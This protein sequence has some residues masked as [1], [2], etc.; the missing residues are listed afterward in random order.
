MESLESEKHARCQFRRRAPDPVPRG[1]ARKSQQPDLRIKLDEDILR[2][3]EE[4]SRDRVYRGRTKAI[5]RA[6]EADPEFKVK[7][8]QLFR[9]HLTLVPPARFIESMVLKLLKRY[10]DED[11]A[12]A[13]AARGREPAGQ[14]QDMAGSADAD[15]MQGSG[16]APLGQVEWESDEEDG[17]DEDAAEGGED[18]QEQDHAESALPSQSPDRGPSRRGGSRSQSSP[19]SAMASV[20]VGT[21]L[22]REFDGD[23]Y[24]G[25]VFAITRAN[26]GGHS[27]DHMDMERWAVVYDDADVEEL[28]VHDLRTARIEP[29]NHNLQQAGHTDFGLVSSMGFLDLKRKL[30]R[31]ASTVTFSDI[32]SCGI[33]LDLPSFEKDHASRLSLL[34]H[35]RRACVLRVLRLR[36]LERVLRRVHR[37]LGTD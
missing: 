11:K 30:G 32:S 19:T 31:Q 3:I 33:A 1:W 25:T 37:D 17:A 34:F 24:C 10:N 12:L 18:E 8:T 35:V 29:S 23:W 20:V 4:L 28:D 27:S 14:G 6:L 26:G 7:T 22:S 9:T 13:A 5:M 16:N 2:R 15:E 21:R 36:M